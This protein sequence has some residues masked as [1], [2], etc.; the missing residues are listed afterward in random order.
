VRRITPAAVKRRLS[1]GRALAVSQ[2]RAA[3]Y[4][5]QHRGPRLPVDFE[6]WLERRSGRKT[7]EFPDAWR[8]DDRLD[9]AEPSTVGVLLH[10]FYPELVPEI[11]GQLNEIPVRFDLIVTNASG[12][13][14][15]FDRTDLP[16]ARHIRVLDVDN[17][18]RD[19]WPMAQVV[20]AGLLDPYELVLKVHTKRSEWRSAHEDLAGTGEGWRNTLLTDLLGDRDNIAT[21]M[22]A[23]AE[24]PN[25]GVVTAAGNLLGPEFWGGDLAASR[26]LL[27]RLE[28]PLHPDGLCFPSGS[29]YWIRGFV[30]QGLRALALTSEDF[31]RE[32]GQI[33]GTTAHAIERV[34]GILAEEAGLS[35]GERSTLSV[36]EPDGWRRFEYG[37]PRRH[38][39]RVIPFY[40]PQFHP[41]PENDRWWGQGFTEW[42]NVTAA[43]PVYRGHN[44][45]NLPSDLGFYDLRLDA[46]RQAQMD[47]ASDHG[48]EGFM[49]YYYWFAGQRL[50]S[51]PVES[52]LAS[53]V[54][55]R[56]C[57]MWA[58]ENWTRRWDGRT[59]DILMGQDY[60]RVPA[61]LFID[62]VL[63]FLHDSRYLRVGGM[64][65]LAVYRVGQIPN[66]ASVL[67]HWRERARAAGIGELFVLNVDVVREFD[68]LV[69]RAKQAGL[70]GTLGF[71]PHNLKWEWVPHGGLGVNRRFKGNI[72]DYKAMVADADRK[73]VVLDD[74]EFP[75]VMV[76]FDNTARR[77][78]ASDLWFGANPYTFRRW[79]SAAASAVAHREPDRRIVFVNAWN[80][81]AESAVLEPTHRFGRTYLLAVRDVVHG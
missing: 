61:E 4:Q 79:L 63:P 36:D 59:S 55:K 70:D 44:Q 24:N 50:L 15:S 38:R 65:V 49:Y 9:V 13:Q 60:N 11:I 68:G 35:L 39:T 22:S 43:R 5:W 72:L 45:P 6:L 69:G 57:L 19:I 76:T 37:R 58:N 26:E 18:G 34:I 42:T 64:P 67:D 54:K 3:Q 20:N 7:A 81:W 48:V 28:L 74:H 33:D 46:V 29:F 80:E 53:A 8:S 71:P 51:G 30:L 77:Q 78:W 31:E 66:F 12:E 23:F 27:R 32:A 47:L 62:D 14:I 17:R 16:R 75:G 56:F 52:L 73:M 41:I 2:V 25:L 1:R 10:V 21:V 40:L